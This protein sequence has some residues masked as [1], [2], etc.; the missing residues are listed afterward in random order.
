MLFT[1]PDG[2]RL[3]SLD[4]FMLMMPF[5]M[6]HRV[7]ASNYTTL[8]LDYDRVKPYIQARKATDTPVSLMTIVIAA[9]VRTVAA[10]PEVNRFVVNRKIYA[11]H[12]I[13]FSFITLREGW[14][15]E[16][17]Q[18]ETAV[19][20]HFTGWETIDEIQ[21]KLEEAIATNRKPE[22][23]NSID[24]FLSGLFMLPVLPSFL[25]SCLKMLDRHNLLPKS[26]INISPFHAGMFFTNMASIR[27]PVILHHLYEFG[28]VTQFLALGYSTTRAKSF[29]L[30]ITLDERLANGA[31]NMR[32]TRYLQSLIYHPE[33][34]ESPPDE[35]KEDV[36]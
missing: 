7:E 27:G 22:N 26:I 16:G 21:Q 33:R 15:G 13:S 30:G 8:E 14:D 5:I 11:R 31:T 9:Y 28:T 24:R 12:G 29:A 3:R 6:K 4:P 17:E 23:E 2:R 32:A 18:P 19:T 20:V 36:K 1:R 25:V 35:V 10:F 34:L